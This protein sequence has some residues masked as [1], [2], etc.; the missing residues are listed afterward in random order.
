MSGKSISFALIA[1]LVFAVLPSPSP[2]C[3]RTFVS[4]PDFWVLDSMGGEFYEGPPL[5]SAIVA[6]RLA[7]LIQKRGAYFDKTDHG[8]DVSFLLLVHNGWEDDRGPASGVLDEPYDPIP[9]DNSG[10]RGFPELGVSLYT[11]SGKLYK[12]ADAL[13][14]DAMVAIYVPAS[15]NKESGRWKYTIDKAYGFFSDAPIL[16]G[17]IGGKY[18]MHN[19]M[20]GVWFDAESRT[21]K[22]PDG[23][24]VTNDGT[25]IMPDR[26]IMTLGGFTI[27]PDRKTD[28]SAI[29]NVTGIPEGTL[30]LKDGTT[31][32]PDGTV[33]TPDGTNIKRDG[34]I[35]HPPK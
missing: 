2:L 32:K 4:N 30:V 24:I 19:G 18:L 31:I 1:A 33:V 13:P 26:S 15:D 16:L 20:E 9:I 28:Q 6:G 17:V 29:M 27:T 22:L 10:Y 3:A 7:G 14:G 5:I 23:S 8:K 12:K 35:E 25:K 34:T 21:I 11:P